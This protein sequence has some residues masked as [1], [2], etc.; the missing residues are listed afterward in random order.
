MSMTADQPAAATVSW[1]REAAEAEVDFDTLYASTFQGL[2]LQL[3]AYLGDLGEAQ[4]A[5]QEAFCRAYQRW[6]KISR[7]DNPVAWVRRVAWNE[8]TSHA[9]RRRRARDLA[10]RLEEDT[11][12]GPDPDHVALVRA[13]A[14]LPEPQRKVLVLHY[15]GHLSVAEIAAQ[16]R[17]A[18][19]TV[20]SR[21]SRGRAALAEQLEGGI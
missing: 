9:R 4:D 6:T 11:V 8:A 20:K 2:T 14:A 21:L 13:L 19:G 16:E 1:P 7:Y 5:V 17:V 3:Y 12:P 15:L 18:A 10:G